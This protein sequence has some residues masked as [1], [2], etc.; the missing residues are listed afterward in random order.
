[1]TT[2]RIPVY[3]A[4]VH[5]PVLN[6]KGETI[7]TAVTNLDVHDGCRMSAT[8]GL[9]RFFLVTPIEEQQSLVSRITSHW[10][11]GPG[12]QKNP[13]RKIAMSKAMAVKSLKEASECI[14][15]DHG[16][17]PIVVGTSARRRNAEHTTYEA[18]TAK[19][20]A[21]QDDNTPL[22]II[23][24][25]GWGI[26]EDIDPP[27]QLMLPAIWGGTDYNHLSVRAAMAITLDRLL[28]VE[29]DPTKD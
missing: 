1:M 17:P 26:T 28:A 20:N 19:I 4:L 25:T 22:L 29:P 24:G 23:F 14:I 18:L 6:R 3:M 9:D 12:A 16:V 11:T 21:P 13:K 15:N 5:Y 10:V 27:L 8:Y 7:A 2:S